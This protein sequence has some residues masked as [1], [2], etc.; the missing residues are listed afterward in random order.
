MSENKAFDQ[1]FDLLKH[2]TTKIF[3]DNQRILVMQ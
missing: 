2:Y 1:S 3:F